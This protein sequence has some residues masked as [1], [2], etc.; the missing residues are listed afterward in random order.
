MLK[1]RPFLTL[2]ILAVLWVAAILFEIFTAWG[3]FSIVAHFDVEKALFIFFILGVVKVS[4]WAHFVYKKAI[5]IHVVKF[6]K[7]K[8]KGSNDGSK[9]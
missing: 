5:Y 6:I 4:D 1:N 9:E 3:V 2:A 7:E 8:R